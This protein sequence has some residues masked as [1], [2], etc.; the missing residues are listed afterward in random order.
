MNSKPIFVLAAACLLT[1][2]IGNEK[3]Y[4]GGASQHRFLPR[5]SAWARAAHRL[6]LG[7]ARDPVRIHRLG[8][9]EFQGQVVRPGWKSSSAVQRFSLQ[10]LLG[11]ASTAVGL[12]IAVPRAIGL[13]QNEEAKDT[14]VAAVLLIGFAAPT[15]VTSSII[16]GIGRLHDG[17]ARGSFGATLAGTTTFSMVAIRLARNTHNPLMAIG[18]VALPTIGG[19]M[20]YSFSRRPQQSAMINRQNDEWRPGLPTITARVIT[21]PDGDKDIEYRLSILNTTF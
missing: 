15:L 3:A 2:L 6:S 14:S 21:G 11:T 13:A 20:G 1:M 8:R 9:N 4:A 17:E 16:Y 18:L 7:S 10:A 12:A 19:V 5:D